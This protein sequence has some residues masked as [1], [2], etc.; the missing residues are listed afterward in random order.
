MSDWGFPIFALCTVF[1]TLTIL[2]A[3]VKINSDLLRVNKME[4]E[5]QDMKKTLVGNYRG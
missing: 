4:K 1:V 3:L 5:F 2:F